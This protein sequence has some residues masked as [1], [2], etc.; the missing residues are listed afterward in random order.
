MMMRPAWLSLALL[1]ALAACA[2]A[3]PPVTAAPEPVIYVAPPAVVEAPPPPAPVVT[4]P[5]VLRFAGHV[6]SYKSLAEAEAAWPRLAERVP[7]LK[8]ANRRYV[9]VDLGGQRGKVVRLLVGGFPD[10]AEAL[11]YCRSLRGSALY[12]APHDLPAG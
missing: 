6:A 5:P 8:T 1:A 9:E 3:P 2:D 7:A 12:C 11:A 4:P 10:R